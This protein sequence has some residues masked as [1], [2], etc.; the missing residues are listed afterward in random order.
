[1]LASQSDVPLTYRD[2]V[3]NGSLDYL[4]AVKPWVQ[5]E[6]ADVHL[7]GHALIALTTAG[8]LSAEPLRSLLRASAGRCTGRHGGRGWTK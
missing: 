3:L 6:Q 2:H 1:M 8:H 4:V 7:A 5:V